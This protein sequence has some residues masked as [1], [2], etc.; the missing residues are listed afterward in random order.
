MSPEKDGVYAPPREVASPEDCYFYHTID[1]PR[2]GLQKGEWDLRGGEADYLGRCELKGKRVLE[3]GTAN[4]YLCFYMERQGAE[5]VGYDLSENQSW[6]IVPYVH[7]KFDAKAIME[8]RREHIKKTNNAWWLTRGLL[9]S[10]ARVVHGTVY[11]VPEA[12]GPVDIVT[13][14]SI[15]LHVRDPFQAM[16]RAARLCRDTLIVTD[17]PSI[18]RGWKRDLLRRF[19][20]PSAMEFLPRA[21]GRYPYET[22]WILPPELAAEFAK[23]LGFPHV[24]ITYHTQ[25]YYRGDK[26]LY[27]MV[28]RR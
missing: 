14:G 28:A 21:E 2:H 4:G 16:C 19:A 3:I 18:S 7:P 6:D 10:K 25:K 13:F 1:L 5:V 20:S 22:W 26:H 17:V 12:I 8:K 27:T 15:L 24:R 23:I 11:E 9:G